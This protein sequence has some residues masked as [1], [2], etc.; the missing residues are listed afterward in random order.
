MPC[1]FYKK[2][3]LII[4]IVFFQ[5]RISAQTTAQLFLK[6]ESGIPVEECLM[7]DLS[8]QQLLRQQ[9]K[10]SLV[11]NFR[12]TQPDGYTIRCIAGEKMVSTQLWLNP[13]AP[14]IYARITGESLIVDSVQHAPFYYKMLAFKNT[15]Q[16][17]AQQQDTAA[18]NEFLLNTFRENSS[19]PFSLHAGMYFVMRNANNR[20]ELMRLKE[21]SSKQG[22]RFREHLLYSGSVE[23]LNKLI[24]VLHISPGRYM[25]Y[26]TLNKKVRLQLKG[27][28][29]FILD[30]WFLNCPP[31]VAQHRE[32]NA[33][34]DSFQARHIQFVSISIDD[35][36][37]AWAAYLRKHGYR[38]P[39]FRESSGA[40][41]TTDLSISGFPTYLLLNK[42]GD[43]LGNYNSFEGIK[44]WLNAQPVTRSQQ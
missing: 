28:D 26:D 37:T 42:Q 34:L 6:N 38:W 12:L 20:P 44:D 11:F 9:Y 19:N 39:N 5:Q 3:L 23:R 13:G 40:K 8:Q 21:L 25:L 41:L 10:D 24:S 36:H 32:I 1:N 35:T 33:R 31:C 17:L 14:R 18:I 22:D 16:R 2:L 27:A 43:V 4:L 30:F 29:Y 15:Y 7:F